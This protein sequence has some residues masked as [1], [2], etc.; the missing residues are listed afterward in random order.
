MIVHHQN[1]SYPVIIQQGL[2]FEFAERLS[3]LGNVKIALVVDER[4]YSLYSELINELQLTLNL[5]VIP[6]PSGEQS[7]SHETLMTL[8][9]EFVEAGM[10]RSDYV[11]AFGGGVIGDLAG[12]AAATYLR[13]ISLIQVPTTLL[14]QVDS[15]I[16][17]KVAVNLAAGKNLVGSF[18]PPVAVWI[19]PAFVC[20]LTE[21]DY[22]SGLAEMIKTGA[23]GDKTLFNR[24][25]EPA[26]TSLETILKH[27]DLLEEVLRMSL[28]FKAKVVKADPYEKQLRKCL[29]FGHTLGHAA[30]AHGHYKTYT[31]GEAVAYGMF[32]I[33][34][35]AVSKG[36]TP[37]RTHDELIQMLTAFDYEAIKRLKPEALAAWLFTDKKITGEWIE[38]VLLS[39]IG[40]SYLHPMKLDEF[41]AD[42]KRLQEATR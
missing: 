28:N 36:L 7:K 16:G 9:Q 27:L 26:F 42:V 31:H 23:I 5:V 38:L 13:G 41:I 35:Y 12:Y 10:T 33:S 14:S 20:T 3:A 32:W 18:Y 15:S 1:G 22:L 19:D 37:K 29:N 8:Y 11:I 30:E 21:R 17:G 2:R 25:K 6:V 40:E 24:L 4:L 39:D 34:H